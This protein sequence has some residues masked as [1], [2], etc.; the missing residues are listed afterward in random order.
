MQYKFAIF[1]SSGQALLVLDG[2]WDSPAVV[3]FTG[4]EEIKREFIDWLENEVTDMFGHFIKF[5]SLRP[6]D[7]DFV[8]NSFGKEKFNP[9]FYSEPGGDIPGAPAGKVN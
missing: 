7:L 6:V 3:Q 5:D 2:E 9:I 4:D 8:L 1:D